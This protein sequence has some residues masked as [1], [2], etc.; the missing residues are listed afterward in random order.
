MKK[1]TL[2]AIL[3][4]VFI[5]MFSTQSPAKS[6]EKTLTLENIIKKVDKLI[7]N[8]SIMAWD[9]TTK[10]TPVDFES[11]YKGYEWLFTPE[12]IAFVGKSIG[13]KG[14][15]D[16]EKLAR[17]FLKDFLVMQYVEL[18]TAPYD[19]RFTNAESEATVK[20][21]WKDNEVAYRE[22]PILISQE[23]NP[24][25]RKELQKLSAE[26]EIEKLNPILEEKDAMAHKLIKDLGYASY[27]DYSLAAR[28]VKDFR[29]IIKDADTFNKKTETVYK[30][31]LAEFAQELLGMKVSDMRRSDLQKLFRFDPY[32]SYF[33]P[34]VM[35]PFLKYF[36][37]QMGL[38]LTTA[39]GKAI[40]LDDKKR[41][42]K[43]PRAACF[44]IT[45]PS[46]IRMT[47]AP[48]GGIGD[49]S[50]L[51][52]E[53]GHAVHFANTT[54]NEWAFKYLGDYSATESYAGILESLL[55]KPDFLK[56][57]REFVKEWNAGKH[58]AGQ[59]EK[60]VPV[61][62]DKDIAKVVRFGILN[63]L[64][65]MRR[66]GGAKLIYES[67]YHEGAPGL[68]AGIYRG[69]TAD[70][71]E[72]YRAL[73]EKAY[74]FPMEDIDS[75]RYLTDI[76][77]FLYAADY[78]RSFVAISQIDE[79][80]T[81]LFGNKW[82]ENKDSGTYLKEKLFSVGNKLSADEVV[83]MLGYS[84]IDFNVHEKNIRK[85]LSESEKLS[86]SN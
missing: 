66:Y 9:N 26:V 86:A 85:K 47:I 64:Y 49:F 16:D 8:Q 18:A 2:T 36:L 22:I 67:I 76:D 60:S 20:P 55:G 12:T 45:V 63:D 51:F 15:S 72:V 52:H 23:D 42:K 56:F 39:D 82:F 5:F 37:A 1:K 78:V 13:E 21:S 68:W 61:M 71:R 80:L 28:H 59:P 41:P 62:T 30:K 84:G 32:V 77:D 27:L 43:N 53:T 83:S 17:S 6:H 24:E 58:T 4:G 14:I 7:R 54:V 31:L 65:F 48:S 40:K 33:P 75:A 11:T 50:A 46:D 29:K 35:I 69:G 57:Y 25:R 19:D 34:E 3:T 81:K 10:G 73:F 44:N 79:A 70:K 38:D 74:S